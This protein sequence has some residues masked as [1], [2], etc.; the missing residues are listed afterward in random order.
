MTHNGV[1]LYE[2]WK[3]IREGTHTL[4]LFLLLSGEKKKETQKE[5]KKLPIESHTAELGWLLEKKEDGIDNRPLPGEKKKR[6]FF[7][8]GITLKG[9]AA[10]AQP[11][12]YYYYY[13]DDDFCVCVCV[14]FISL[15]IWRGAI[16][17]SFTDC[18]IVHLRG[19]GY[20]SH[21]QIQTSKM[22]PASFL[23]LYPFFFF[24]S[25]S[26]WIELLRTTQ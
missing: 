22:A 24:S 23:S 16:H 11:R 12:W 6:E 4:P 18:S 21:T 10:K 2:C 26:N 20:S 7:R 8:I 9:P 3:F 25:G 13:D 5:A 1:R 14:L 17:K 15:Y 19:V